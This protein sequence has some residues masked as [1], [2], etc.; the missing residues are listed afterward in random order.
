MTEAPREDHQGHPR[1]GDGRELRD[2]GRRDT[3]RDGRDEDRR[4]VTKVS[5]LVSKVPIC[6][7]LS[8][9]YLVRAVG[10]EPTT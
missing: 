1:L 10:I 4:S 8:V 7:L 9:C 3:E 6:R 5:T 2:D